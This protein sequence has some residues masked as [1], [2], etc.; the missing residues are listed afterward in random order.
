MCPFCRENL[1]TCSRLSLRCTGSWLTS[2]TW[3]KVELTLKKLK[4]SWHRWISH[5]L[6]PLLMFSDLIVRYVEPY[7]R[8]AVWASHTVGVLFW[9]FL[10]NL[11]VIF[12]AKYLN[13]VWYLQLVTGFLLSCIY[14]K[15]KTQTS[16]ATILVTKRD[17]LLTNTL[18]PT[19][20]SL[21]KAVWFNFTPGLKKLLAAKKRSCTDSLSEWADFLCARVTW[22]LLDLAVNNVC[23]GLAGRRGVHLLSL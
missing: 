17:E 3:T 16:T 6:S 15:K 19:T 9:G 23:G 10:E 5:D 12:F 22:W 21:H 13:I 18:A 2:V 8:V 1:T 4:S 11:W 20:H 7:Q 14:G